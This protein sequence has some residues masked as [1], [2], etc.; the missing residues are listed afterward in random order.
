[1]PIGAI[2]RGTT[3]ENR[4][5]R[6]DRFL[7]ALPVLRRAE[8]P[9]V[10]DLGFGAKATTAVE[11]FSRLQ[12]VRP[13]IRVLG[14]EIDPERVQ[15]AKVSEREGLS[16]ALGGFEIP[17]P[18]NESVTVIRALNVL[19]QYDVSEVVGAWKTMTERLSPEGVLIEG[20]SNEIGSV[21]SWLSI[22]AEGPL[23]FTISLKLGQL[24]SPSVVAERLPKLLIHRNVPGEAIHRFLK[25]LDRAWA[26]H[27]GLGSFSALQ[28]WQAVL[29]ELKTA[30]WPVLTPKSR[31]KLGELTLPFSA[32]A[33][34]GFNWSR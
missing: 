5:R 2:T 21:S 12:K 14:L 15:R 10:V 17:T 22:T 18:D 23:Q 8:Q 7:A 30:G 9:L 26:K 33:P 19:R 25:E 32:V 24:Q 28:R 3:A 6:V 27:A 16:F 31:A 34:Q 1:M 20:T 4:L 13:D 11:L 29:V